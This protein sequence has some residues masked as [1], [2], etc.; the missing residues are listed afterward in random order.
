LE[1]GKVNQ[2]TGSLVRQFEK[3]FAAKHGRHHG[4]GVANGSVALEIALRAFKIGPGDEVIVPARSFVASA[5]CVALV[6]ATPVF[7]DVDR[8]TEVVSPATI[9]PALSEKT[10]AIIPVHLNGRPCDI[11]G[12][13]RLAAEHKLLV[14]EDCAQS[15]GGRIDGRLLGSFGDAAAFSFCQD[16]IISTGGEGGMILLDD[17]TAWN[18]AWSFKDHGKSY[19]LTSGQ[20][21][22]FGYRWVHE[23]IGTNARL[24]E[25]Q[26]AIGLQ[27]LVKLDGWVAKRNAVAN[28]LVKALSNFP[29]V[30]IAPVPSNHIHA[31]YRL[32]LAIDEANLRHGWD[33]DRVLHALN[34]EGVAAFVGV[35][36]ELYLERAFGSRQRLPNAEALGNVSLVLLTHPTIDERYLVDCERAIEKVFGAASF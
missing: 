11:L 19:G 33:R 8:E 4:V 14:I 15:T 32:E 34:C 29:C 31:R 30:T 12:I 16:K 5:A 13:M 10:R 6:G 22:E 25:I 3:A 35:C 26:A 20:M 23:S 21:F 36:P 9:G 28:R 17:E 2:W 27:Q 1:S 24:T 18:A 7:A